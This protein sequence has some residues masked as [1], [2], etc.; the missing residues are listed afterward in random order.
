[1]IGTNTT[2]QAVGDACMGTRNVCGLNGPGPLM[3]L[4]FLRGHGQFSDKLYYQAFEKC[5]MDDLIGFREGNGDDFGPSG[6]IKN[7]TCVDHL[8]L[9][10]AAVGPFYVYNLYD[11][12][13]Y[14]N[15][16]EPPHNT[17]TK[18][19]SYFSRVPPHSLASSSSKSGQNKQVRQRMV[20]PNLQGAVN[21][22]PCGGDQ[23][24]FNWVM[25]PQVKKALHVS[26][27]ASFFS[28]DN[29][30]GFTYN[31]TEPD[32]MPFYFHVVN[33]T[34][35][36]VLVYNGDSDPSINSFTAQNWTSGLGIEE[37]KAWRPW[38]VDGKQYIGGYVTRYANDF[39]YL[40][41]RGAGTLSFSPKGKDAA[42]ECVLPFENLLICI[43]VFPVHLRLLGHMVP[44][45]K[46]KVTFEFLSK[47]L[48]NEEWLGW[49]SEDNSPDDIRVASK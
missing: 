15:D 31:Q 49:D 41:I 5:S 30:V 24:F 46:P 47:W 6:G 35:L 14:Q 37:T 32:L 2:P 34:D 3:N 12:C 16:L 9:I 39:D 22:Y 36:R 8:K 43:D 19:R 21:D 42:D 33:N 4:E 11:A 44:Q 17:L 13:W 29:G 23:A 1:M 20:S 27:N 48:K 7:Q 28:G 18:P 25:T 40:T 26:P 10:E 45:Y 38:T